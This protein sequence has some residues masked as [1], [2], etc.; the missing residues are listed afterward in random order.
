MHRDADG[1]AGMMVGAGAIDAAVVVV[2]D[3]VADHAL[4]LAIFGAGVAALLVV[5][6]VA[7]AGI[8][9][10]AA[11]R[12]IMRDGA[13]DDGACNRRGLAAVAMADRVAERAANQGAEHG[14]AGA[15]VAAASLVAIARLVAFD[16]L[17]PADIP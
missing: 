15:V 12:R 2:G 7:A 14:R 1:V 13:T 4:L 9:I 17:V 5:L 16:R 8:A 10:T 11:M 3:V 6:H